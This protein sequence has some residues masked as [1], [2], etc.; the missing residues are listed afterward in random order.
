MVSDLGVYIHIPYCLQRCRYCD[1]ATYEEGQILPKSEYAKLLNKEISF[2]APLY[3]KQ[4]LTSIY[5]GG[6]TPSLFEPDL[7][8]GILMALQRAGLV[9][10]NKSTEITMEVNPATLTQEKLKDY[11]SLGVNRMSVGAQSFNNH[12]LK[13]VDRRHD[14]KDT[15]LTLELLAKFGVSYSLDILFAL[16]K[17]ELTHLKEDLKIVRELA[18]K[19]VSTY[20]LT[21]PNGHPMDKGRP[22]DETQIKMFDLIDEALFCMGLR[23][24]EISNYAVPGFESRHN[25]LYW[26]DAAYLAFGLS[27]HGYTKVSSYGER[28]WN[29]TNIKVYTEKWREFNIMDSPK[30]LLDGRHSSQYEILAKHQA[31]TDFCHTSL[32]LMEGLDFKRLEQKF[33]HGVLNKVKQLAEFLQNEGLVEST[34]K[35]FRLTQKGV[36]LSNQVFA[37]LTF[38]PEDL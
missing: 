9:F 13:S 28:F 34:I 36:I 6:G 33:G 24:Y 1:F 23:R 12:L 8:E 27:A 15:V 20:C 25:L 7:I 16:P 2:Y 31:L 18:P 37:K 26:Q 35:G 22:P 5:F 14:A 17:Q 30:S 11:L 29:E 4:P 10:D 19:H 32:R 3:Q 38:L 21:V